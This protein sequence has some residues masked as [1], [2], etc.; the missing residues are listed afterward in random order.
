MKLFEFLK[1]LV[2]YFQRGWMWLSL[3]IQAATLFTVRNSPELAILV[4]GGI[5]A[6]IGG[7]ADIRWGTMKNQQGIAT[8]ANPYSTSRL[9]P[10]EKTIYRVHLNSMRLLRDMRK[11]R[12]HPTEE[13]DRDICAFD[14]LM[15]ENND[16]KA[17]GD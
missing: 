9:T 7:Y 14:R 3:I 12:G 16:V 11:E 17:F 10:K 15:E 4:V 6:T 5:A 1:D 2:V 8:L 13:L